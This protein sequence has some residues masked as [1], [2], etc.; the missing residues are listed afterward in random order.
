MTAN[1]PCTPDWKEMRRWRALELKREGCIYQEVA[2]AL[3][4]TKDA[5]SRW[6][7]AVC[8]EGETGLQARLCSGASPKL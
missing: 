8:E 7:T 3:G 2:D 4:V 6:M 1:P 5:V